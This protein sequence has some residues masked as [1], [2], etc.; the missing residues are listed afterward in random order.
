MKRLFIQ[1]IAIALLSACAHSSPERPAKLLGDPA[2]VEA[3]T[4]TIVLQPGTRWVNVTGGDIVKFVAGDKAFGWA[5][6]VGSSVTSFDLSRVAPP[7]I[8]NHPVMAYVAPDPRYIG[9]DGDRSK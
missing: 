2:P 4:K 5:F 8:L 7:G 1:S 3:A 6:N 9:G